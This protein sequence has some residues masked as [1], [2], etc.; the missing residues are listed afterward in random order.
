[1]SRPAVFM[2]LKAAGLSP[3]RAVMVAAASGLMEPVGALL[4]IGLGLAAG[5]MIFVVSH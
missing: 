3:L 5:A 1:M 4:G 2:S